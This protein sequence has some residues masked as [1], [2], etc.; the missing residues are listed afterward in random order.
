MK[1]KLFNKKNYT[2][3]CANCFYGRMPKDKLSVLCEKKGIM[4]LDD[5][6]KG[7]KY[8]P[9]KRIPNRLILSG[10]YTEDDFKL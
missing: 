1:Q 3:C 5:T 4:R 10:N 7:Y 9:L 8:D 2:K 6:C